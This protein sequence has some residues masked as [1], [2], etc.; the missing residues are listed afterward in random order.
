M[1]FLCIYTAL[2][3]QSKYLY[4]C[5]MKLSRYTDYSLRALIYLAASDGRLVSIRQIAEAHDISQNHLMKIVQDL[6]SAG[7][8]RTT[9]G[10]QGGLQLARPAIEITIGQVVRHTEGDDPLVDCSTCRISQGC[11]L[12][13]VILQAREA[14]MG[15]LDTCRLSDVARMPGAFQHLFPVQDRS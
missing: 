10:R 15:V 14:F 5:P 4:L 8:I 7:F 9:R 3:M 1:H 13:A 11:G 12:P 2:Y 6:G